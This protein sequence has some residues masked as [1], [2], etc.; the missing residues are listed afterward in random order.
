ML[1]SLLE[2]IRDKCG[3]SVT[4]GVE[5]MLACSGPG[6]LLVRDPVLLPSRTCPH[7]G[8]SLDSLLLSLSVVQF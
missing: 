8:Y 4:E 2:F 6:C 1:D 3:G 7:R 5:G